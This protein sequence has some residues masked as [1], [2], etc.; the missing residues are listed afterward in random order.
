M[1]PSELDR[2]GRHHAVV[3]ARDDGYL[4]WD[5]TAHDGRPCGAFL[6]PYAVPEECLS[7]NAKAAVD[8][9]VDFLV[10]TYRLRA[11][12]PGPGRPAGQPATI[13]GP[14]PNPNGAFW[15]VF[16]RDHLGSAAVQAELPPAAAAFNVPPRPDLFLGLQG[17]GGP[18]TWSVG[19][20]AGRLFLGPAVPFVLG[21][22]LGAGLVHAGGAD[23][24]AAVGGLGLLLPLVRRL[25]IGFAPAGFRVACDT[26]LGGCRVDPIAVLGQLLVPLGQEVWLGVEG[27]RWSWTARAIGESWGALALGWSYEWRPRPPPHAPADVAAWDPP[28]PAEARTYRDRRWTRIVYLAATAVSQTDN[29]FIGAGLEWRVDRDRW[30]RRAGLG[31]GVQIE[32]DAGR[33]D[34]AARGGAVALGPTVRGYVS[35]NRLALTA[36]PALVRVGALADRPLAVD[37]AGRVGLGLSLGRVEI[38]VDSPPLSYL[39]TARWHALPFTGRLGLAMD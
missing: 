12:A 33:I 36:T 23:Q 34:G 1:R 28:H 31:A 9:V 11:A 30:N 13:T 6:H 8:A 15:L 39:T 32:I 20:W 38:A 37:V 2:L 4:R 10:L 21:L 29:Q 16:V 18:D 27:P 25:T 3:D 26:H 19:L 14:P 5:A 7:A 22:S 17:G 35:A 24:L